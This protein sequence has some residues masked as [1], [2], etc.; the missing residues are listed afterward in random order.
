MIIA[1]KRPHFHAFTW[2]EFLTSITSSTNSEL[3]KETFFYGRKCILNDTATGYWIICKDGINRIMNEDTI[4]IF[5]GVNN[6]LTATID[7]ATFEEKYEQV[8]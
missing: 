3:P 2:Q 6:S 8:E 4:M 7:Y 5:Y 1:E